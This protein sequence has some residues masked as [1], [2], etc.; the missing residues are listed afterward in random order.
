MTNYEKMLSTRPFIDEV[1]WQKQAL[2]DEGVLNQKKVVLAAGTSSGKT[3]FTIMLLNLFY[4]ITGNKKKKTL[5]VPSAQTNLRTNFVQALEDF[6]PDFKWVVAQSCEELTTAVNSNAQVIVVLPQTAAM[7]LDVLPKL[8]KFILDEA[9]TWYFKKTIKNIIKKTKPE[10]QLLLTGTPAPFILRG[11]FHMHFVPVM[12]LYDEGRIANTEVHVVSS[13]YNFKE[14][15]YNVNDNLTTHAKNQTLLASEES[16]RKVILGMIRKLRNPIKG[17]KNLNRLTNDAGGRFFKHLDKTIIWVNS[18]KQADKFAQVLR[19]F[20]GMQNAVLVSHSENDEDSELM[21]KFKSDK[22]IRVLVTVN[23]GRMGWSYTELYHAVDFTMTRNLSSILQMMARLFRISKVDPSKKKYFYKVSNSN[24][25]GY[26]TVIMKG[27][28]LLLDREWYSQFNGR[29]FNGMEIPVTVPRHRRPTNPDGTRRPGRPRTNYRYEMLDIPLDMNFFKT[30]YAK[31]DDT[32]S[33]VAWTTIGEVRKQLFGYNPNILLGRT[34][35][36]E[37][38]IAEAK[39]FNTYKQYRKAYPDSAPFLYKNNLGK[40]AFG[41][42]VDW[43]WLNYKDDKAYLTSIL[44]KLKVNSW[45]ELGKLKPLETGMKSPY[46]IAIHAKKL[47]IDVNKI[48]GIK[49][50]TVRKVQSYYKSKKLKVYNSC[51]EAAK[52]LNIT[53]SAVVNICNGRLEQRNGYKFKYIK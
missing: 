29:N 2:F 51:T 12:D 45:R 47:G 32:F 10:Q 27:V 20:N 28:L 24:D 39:K 35:T 26:F 48:L 42:M 31:Q 30:V 17:T 18:I 49:K 16:F 41:H 53:P 52:D 1:K 19:E 22:D 46:S 37:E 40:E 36:F 21:E 6:G 34:K 50:G 3:F 25:A 38:R 9:H 7:C 14:E 13:N 15:D 4:M 5:I 11:G 44:S 33:T 43:Q 8:D 23:R